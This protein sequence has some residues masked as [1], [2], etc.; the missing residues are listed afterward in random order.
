MVP[1][2]HERSRGPGGNG[3]HGS[4]IRCTNYE[5]RQTGKAGFGVVPHGA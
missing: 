5:H 1:I 4:G 2:P 3:T